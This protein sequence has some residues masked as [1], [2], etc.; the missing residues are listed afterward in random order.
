V[1]LLPLPCPLKQYQTP[2]NIHINKRTQ[3][4]VVQLSTVSE[5]KEDDGLTGG[6]RKVPNWELHNL[7]FSPNIRAM[8]SRRV[9][10]AEHTIYHTYVQKCWKEKA[11]RTQPQM[12]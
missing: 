3:A 4:E 12:G 1:S 2:I 10:L 7:H 9:R 8:K 5:A 6:W 11:W